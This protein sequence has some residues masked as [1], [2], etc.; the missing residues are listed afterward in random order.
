MDD[1]ELYFEDGRRI[2]TDFHQ[3]E[4]T[5]DEALTQILAIIGDVR[6]QERERIHTEIKRFA[7]VNYLIVNNGGLLWDIIQDTLKDTPIPKHELA[8]AITKAETQLTETIEE[9]KREERERV[10]G[11]Y[12]VHHGTLSPANMRKIMLGETLS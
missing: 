3:G 10:T 2:L 6:K 8:K 9:A 4:I 12:T 7:D 1:R 5:R 11:L